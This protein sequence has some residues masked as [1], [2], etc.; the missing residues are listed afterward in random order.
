MCL[1]FRIIQGP[2]A[3]GRPK[4]KR[5]SKTRKT[6]SKTSSKTGTKTGTK[7]PGPQDPDP[8]RLIQPINDTL[9]VLTRTLD[10]EGCEENHFTVEVRMRAV[11][12]VG[13]Q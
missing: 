8:A 7:R 5:P 1:H 13:G 9:W 10:N 4:T 2:G 12:M 3:K 6:S 11:V